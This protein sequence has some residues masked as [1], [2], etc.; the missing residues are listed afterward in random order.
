MALF[1]DKM[2]YKEA[3]GRNITSTVAWVS[4]LTLFGQLKVPSHLLK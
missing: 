1:S 2:V 4:Q 3:G